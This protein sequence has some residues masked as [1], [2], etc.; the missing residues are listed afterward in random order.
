MPNATSATGVPYFVIM[1]ACLVALTLSL[2]DN[3]RALNLPPGICFTASRES[4]R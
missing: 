4:L 1:T 3:Q 2:A